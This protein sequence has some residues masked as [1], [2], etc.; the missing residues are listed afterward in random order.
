MI[1]V[2]KCDIG[3][4]VG[5]PNCHVTLKEIRTILLY[6]TLVLKGKIQI[7]EQISRHTG[8]GLYRKLSPNVT[9]GR[10]GFKIGPKVSRL[11]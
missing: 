5:L 3:K 7:S 2:T 8:W 11:I 6:L 9:W 1:L 4:G 10:E